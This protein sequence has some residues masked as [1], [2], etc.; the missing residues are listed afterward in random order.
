MTSAPWGRASDKYGRRP[1]MLICIL[2]SILGI[3]LLAFTVLFNWSN[4]YFIAGT[5][6]LLPI[7]LL[8][9]AR[10]I[11]GSVFNEY[12][13]TGKLPKDIAT[14][15]GGTYKNKGWKGWKDFLGTG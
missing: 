3:S 4:S 9:I 14:S 10:L 8:F 11:D 5:S 13:K 12:K 7:Y 15:P 1:V 2:G 6:S